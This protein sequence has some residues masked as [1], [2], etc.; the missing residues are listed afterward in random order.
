[1]LGPDRFHA[2]AIELPAPTRDV[3]TMLTLLRL[4]LRTTGAVARETGHDDRPPRLDPRQR[5]R[6]N[7]DER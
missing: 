6:G 2:R 7:G 3:K 5:P 1:M 4:D